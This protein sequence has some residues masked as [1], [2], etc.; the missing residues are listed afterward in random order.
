MDIERAGRVSL[1]GVGLVMT[2]DAVLGLSRGSGWPTGVA[3]V[4]GVLLLGASVFELHTEPEVDRP[5]LTPYVQIVGFLLA[6]VGFALTLL[7]SAGV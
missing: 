1:V 4:G 7:D 3:L 5:Q 6:T 2:A